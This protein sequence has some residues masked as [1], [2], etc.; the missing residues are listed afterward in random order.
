[1]SNQNKKIN[2]FNILFIPKNLSRAASAL[3]PAHNK[4]LIQFK[5]NVGTIHKML[6]IQ[7]RG[8]WEN[9]SLWVEQAIV[10]KQG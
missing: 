1:M 7:N 6:C 10:I 3:L 4:D 9:K 2:I 8:F 5:V